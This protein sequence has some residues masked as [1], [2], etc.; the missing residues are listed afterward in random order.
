MAKNAD[1]FLVVNNLVKNDCNMARLK[2]KPI[3]CLKYLRKQVF[4]KGEIF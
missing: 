1:G 2:F 3:C 4:I